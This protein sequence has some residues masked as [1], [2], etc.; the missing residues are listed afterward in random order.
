MARFEAADVQNHCY[1]V[2]DNPNTYIF[3]LQKISIIDRDLAQGSYAVCASGGAG[4]VDGEVNLLHKPE[5]LS[6]NP[7]HSY[8]KPGLATNLS[9][10]PAPSEV[11]GWRVEGD[12]RGLLDASLAPGSS[13]RP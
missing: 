5:D 6:S 8:Q 1:T 10:T 3:P 4:E 13:G 2:M 11:N 7:Q 12:H 9:L